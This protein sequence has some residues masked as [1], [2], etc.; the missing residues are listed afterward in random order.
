MPYKKRTVEKEKI[1]RSIHIND[2]IIENVKNL[3]KKNKYVTP[4]SLSVSLGIR[5]SILKDL[6]RKLEKDGVVKL[7]T[8]NSRIHVYVAAE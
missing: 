3:L 5:V 2:D 1:T 4:Q 6:L 8:G 7:Y